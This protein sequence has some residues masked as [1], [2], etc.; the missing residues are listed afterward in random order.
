[1]GK[2]IVKNIGTWITTVFVFGLVIWALY[3]VFQDHGTAP[4]LDE[5]GKVI[6]DKWD[7]SKT[8][9]LFVLPLATAACGYW[10]GNKGVSDANASADDAK[11][12]QTAAQA[13]TKAVVATASSKLPAGTDILA[14]AKASHPD[15]FGL[16]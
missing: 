2:E 9:L 6:L 7:N 12:G 10:F 14:E 15:A 1:M 11:A 8:T 13:E 4:T 3:Y 5:D 16:K